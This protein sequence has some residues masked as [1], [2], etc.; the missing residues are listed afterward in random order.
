MKTRNTIGFLV[1]TPAL[2]SLVIGCM[3]S[4][5]PGKEGMG[6]GGDNGMT[7]TG[8]GPATGA[9]GGGGSGTTPC[10]ALAAI[11]RRIW[12]LSSQQ[13]ANATRDLLGLSAAPTLIQTTTD[14]SSAYA[15]INGADLTVQ[16]GYLFGGL[17]QT[18]E[19]IVAQIAPRL[20]AIAA[21]NNGEAPV[22]CA[23]RFAQR[24]GAKVFRRPLEA[25]EV[26]NLMK[27]Y[28]QGATQDFNT[29]ISLM[30]EA[31]ILSPSFIYR[32][33]L[34]PSTLTADASGHFP[35]TTLTPYEVATQLGFLFLDSTPDDALLAAAADNSLATNDGVAT[36]VARLLALP[37]TTA[38][39]SGVVVN[40][41]NVGQLVDKANKD[42]TLLA[43]LAPADQDQTVL[44]G[45]LLTSAQQFVADVLFTSGGKVTDLVTSQKV[46]VNKRLATLYGLP[47]TGT[48]NGFAAATFPPTQ[49]RSG[50]L[51]QP[52]FLWSASDPAVNSI[53]KRGKF[54][55][56]D[57]VCQD[58]LPPP[59]DLTTPAALAIIGMG[60]SEITHSDAR[61]NPNVVCSSCHSQM[62][63]YSRVLQNFGPIGN[64]RTVDEVGRPV[65]PSITFKIGPLN[66][67][68]VVGA[69]GL[70]Q[71]LQST[72]VLAGCAVQKMTSYAI[73]N[74][75]KV[76]NTCEL[77]TIRADF[78]QSDG[79]IKSLL[80]RVAMAPFVRARAGGSL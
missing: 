67:M 44:V 37:A 30:I 24:F 12:R 34:G 19:N 76:Y 49:T 68:T 42:T 62:D 6:A 57:V 47:F 38:S 78:D 18:A 74:V 36:Q 22:A 71:A 73:G 23:T 35:D 69:P 25:A 40:W 72:K 70:A 51:T 31:L 9:G 17:Y 50:I 7:G 59:I 8:N 75:I 60:D 13:Y 80:S 16:P 77:Q 2:L 3:G 11:P 21:C 28:T 66:G 54:I 27:V 65:D 14:G 4:V 20:T 52:A 48:G 26:T 41:F 46:F 10:T 39:L 55:H 29:G 79:T 43:A 53:V 64:Y 5:G 45:D 58:P 61:M 33:E 15:F 63:P 1:A 56:D 32:T